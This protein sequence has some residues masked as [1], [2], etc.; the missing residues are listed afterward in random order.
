M[1]EGGRSGTSTL[2]FRPRSCVGSPC[3]EG[4][5]RSKPVVGTSKRADLRAVV[6]AGAIKL[7]PLLQAIAEKRRRRRRWTRMLR[8]LPE[9]AANRDDVCNPRPLSSSS[10]PSTFRIDRPECGENCWPLRRST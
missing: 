5:H 2:G 6:Q 8:E 1:Q 7:K 10:W 3:D 4:W 9:I